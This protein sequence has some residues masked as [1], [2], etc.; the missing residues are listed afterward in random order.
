MNRSVNITGILGRTN[1][2]V[3][4]TSLH[5]AVPSEPT[6]E[7]LVDSERGSWATVTLADWLED[8]GFT[9]GDVIS[10]TVGPGCLP[11]TEDEYGGIA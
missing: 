10:I 6:L 7:V 8:Q 3:R 2:E 4:G 1:A 9:I 5:Y 11:D